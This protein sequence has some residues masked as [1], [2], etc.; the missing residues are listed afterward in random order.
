MWDYVRGATRSP[1]LCTTAVW[2][3]VQKTSQ[4]AAQIR[5]AFVAINVWVKVLP[6][7]WC[8]ATCIIGIVLLLDDMPQH[9]PV[10]L[11]RLWH[12]YDD[13]TQKPV[14]IRTAGVPKCSLYQSAPICFCLLPC[15]FLHTTPTV[16]GTIW[17]RNLCA[18]AVRA[19]IWR[20][21]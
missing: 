14:Y 7:E 10:C 3:P 2:A 4:Q 5:T 16:R 13:V 19:P 12:Q 20:S 18:K 17:S 21:K 8:T 11:Q 6:L 9:C 1:K 15:T